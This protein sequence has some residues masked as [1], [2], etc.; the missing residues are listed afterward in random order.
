MC[1]YVYVTSMIFSGY[2]IEAVEAMA[3]GQQAA[4]IFLNITLHVP[5]EPHYVQPCLI[6][7][8]YWAIFHF[9]HGLC[10]YVDVRTCVLHNTKVQHDTTQ[11]TNQA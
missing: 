3:T 5:S 4:F 10:S 2:A 6:S 11:M 9:F 7:A 8:H 1:M